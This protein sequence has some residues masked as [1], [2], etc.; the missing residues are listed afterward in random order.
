MFLLKF[1]LLFFPWFKPLRVIVLLDV[2]ITPF[3]LVWSLNLSQS[4]FFLMFL[5]FL[6]PWFETKLQLLLFLIFFVS[7]S[8]VQTSYSYYFSWCSCC[9]FFCSKFKPRVAIAF[10]DVLVVLLSL[11]WS[12]EYVATTILLNVL[13]VLLSLVWSSNHSQLFFFLM[14]LLLLSW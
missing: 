7:L 14:F 8:L 2:L 13:V 3:S 5:L 9:S 10:H 1:L 6:A 12:F 11:L 4:L